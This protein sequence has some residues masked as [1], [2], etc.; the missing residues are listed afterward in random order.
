M[1]KPMV[2]AMAG[3][4]AFAMVATTPMS[5][6]ASGLIQSLYDTP[7]V[8]S[9]ESGKTTG[10]GTKTTTKRLEAPA[11]V[12]EDEKW[13][14]V[15][16]VVESYENG[17]E[18][19]TA[20]TTLSTT[21]TN[22]LGNFVDQDGEKA[23]DKHIVGVVFDKDVVNIEV[24][25]EVYLTATVLLSDG[26][27]F[28]YDPS[29]E[30]LGE[31]QG[32]EINLKDLLVFKKL[33]T[34]ADGQ[35]LGAADVAYAKYD[36]GAAGMSLYRRDTL[37]INGKRGGSFYI[38]AA[39]KTDKSE[40]YKFF[41]V[42]A[43]NVKEYATD[44]ELS[45]ISGIAKHTYNLNDYITRTPG[46][47][48]DNITFTAYEI[49]NG[50]EVATKYVTVNKDNTLTI[51]KDIN[52]NVYVKAV[53]EKAAVADAV[54]TTM[55]ATPITDL[56][57]KTPANKKVALGFNDW[58]N[59][60]K[61]RLST[62]LEVSA[63]TGKGGSKTEIGDGY[64]MATTDEIVWTVK[65]QKNKEAVV[66]VAWD[67]N[68]PRKATITAL[69]P[70]KTTV[71]AQ[72]TSGKK[73]VF[74][75][76]VT[77]DLQEITAIY[78]GNGNTEGSVYAGQKIQLYA[79]K[80]PGNATTKITWESKDKKKATVDKNGVVT[81]SPKNKDE[82]LGT[83]EI[84]A[85]FNRVGSDGRVAE[86]N[87][88]AKKT[89]TLTVMKSELTADKIIL[90]D[91]YRI[92][93]ET[94]TKPNTA[95]QSIKSDVVYLKRNDDYDAYG[96]KKVSGQYVPATVGDGTDTFDTALLNN[97]LTWT[98]SKGQVVS[99]NGE[100][101]AVANSAG[102]ANLTASVV[103]VK[104]K[105]LTAKVSVAA[106][107]AVE[108]IQMNKTVVNVSPDKNGKIKDFT[109]KVSKQLPAKATKE[110]FRWSIEGDASI[111]LKNPDNADNKFNSNKYVS[112]TASNKLQFTNAKVGDS[113]TVTITAANG[114]KATVEVNV[115]NPTTKLEFRTG[116]AFDANG[117]VSTA[118]SKVSKAQSLEV[119]SAFEYNLN[120]MTV[121]NSKVGTS[122]TEWLPGAEGYEDVTFSVNKA[123]IVTIGRDGTVY[124]VKAGTVKITA[125]TPSGK[126]ATMTIKVVNPAR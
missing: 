125:Q 70:G 112:S 27:T 15:K 34:N 73:V 78:D 80:D 107:Q 17:V 11:D 61:G 44:I 48:N 81:A 39:L 67:E 122:S 89:F 50:K 66:R 72:A 29:D 100:G 54:V 94:F 2:K 87:V 88:Y 32:V 92:G 90:D 53:S 19:F 8:T 113:A 3:A 86:K 18:N 115:V 5:A 41:D 82:N 22:G 59:N 95:E 7:S 38:Q 74:N 30:S 77:S 42:V 126:K 114:A 110:S 79:D 57:A 123:G 75:V 103:N 45:D 93:K 101:F 35:T 91:T 84:T 9:E 68:D 71:T 51:K 36:R 63:W 120:A 37:K 55:P 97:M 83:V 98:T 40:D 119:G 20:T 117:K 13:N 106:T 26:T 43:V 60:D 21:N 124:G 33:Q 99:V 52:T 6:S 96:I 109:L 47:S 14:P 118:G 23:T 49:K 104:G 85:K 64:S 121:I 4:L 111:R 102:K 25:E 46:T 31:K 116:V 1:K 28:K 62:E 105:K 56:K 108:S 58:E 10:S 76:T 24:G 65:T 69:N 12:P 16:E